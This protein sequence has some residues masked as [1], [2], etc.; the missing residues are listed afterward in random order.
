MSSNSS[1]SGWNRSNEGISS[2]YEGTN[3]LR[4][5]GPLL[6]SS[7]GIDAGEE[8]GAFVLALGGIGGGEATGPFVLCSCVTREGKEL[9]L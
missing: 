9:D 1:S 7:G 3:G 2:T 6:L 4:G 8:T 5:T